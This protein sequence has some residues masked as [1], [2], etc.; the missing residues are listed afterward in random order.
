MSKEENF[1]QQI[2]NMK[3]WNVALNTMTFHQLYYRLTQTHGLK[4]D[5]ALDI[6]NVA[7][8]TVLLDEKEQF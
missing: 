8:V 5:E 6:L 2:F 1:S 3:K 4:E 7:C